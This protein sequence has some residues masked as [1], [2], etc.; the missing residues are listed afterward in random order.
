MILN[1]AFLDVFHGD[2]AVIT[3]DEGGRK[4]CI[5]IDG[6]EK[7][8][9]AARLA[10]YLKHEK[11]EV[12]DLLVATHIDADHVNGLVKFLE[13][14]SDRPNDWNRGVGKCILHYW[15]PK[16]DPNWK[17]LSKKKPAGG[18]PRTPRTAAREFVIQSVQQNQDLSRLVGVHIVDKDNIRYPSLED[19]PPGDIFTGVDIQLLA[20]DTQIFDSA[21][22]AKALT[23]VNPGPLPTSAS[24][25]RLTLPDVRR[26]LADT[27]EAMARIANRNANN[28]SIVIKLVPREGQKSGSSRWS[29]LFSGDA[30]RESWEMMRGITNARNKLRSKVLKLPHH[31]SYLAGIDETS[32]E[33]I[34]PKYN[35]VSVGQKHGLP[36]GQTLNM[37]KKKKGRKLF[38]TERNNSSSHPGPCN[39]AAC[40]RAKNSD[41][42]SIRFIIDTDSG[43]ENI[44]TFT[45][46]TRTGDIEGRP[47]TVWCLENSW[48]EM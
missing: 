8:D 41:F 31:G 35:I 38:C 24:G 1:V 6:G 30:E 9:A 46:N 3:F 4:A 19:M 25:K 48:P 16:P 43:E 15:G 34:K 32:Y 47:D 10:A 28:Q 17:P 44:E 42:R 36:D 39:Q 37:V 23:V 13:G 18:L 14:E 26:I 29:F 11:V 40:V 2:C 22:Q 45:I 5:I 7:Q 20:P 27:N 21:I 12:I 33:M